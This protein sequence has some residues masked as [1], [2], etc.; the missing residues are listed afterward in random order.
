MKQLTLQEQYNLI[1]EGKGD[2]SHFHKQVLKQFPNL[3]TAQSSYNQVVTVLK[4][5]QIISENTTSDTSSEP[6]WFNIFKNNIN[7]LNEEIKAEEKKTSK[8]VEDIQSHNYDY[9]DKKSIDNHSGA[10]F[11]LGFYVE[12][13][14]P[15]NADKT[16][17]EIRNIVVKNLAKDSLYYV[18]DGQF[19]VKGLGYKDEAPGLGKTKEVKGKYASSGME[20]VKLSEAIKKLA[21]KILTEG[22]KKDVTFDYTFEELQYDGDY[23]NIQATIE[24]EVELGE[25]EDVNW[26]IENITLATKFSDNLDEYVLVELT[27]GQV[28]EINRIVKNTFYNDVADV[29]IERAS[30]EEDMY[31]KGG[32][33]EAKKKPSAGLTKK[34]KSTISKK[35]KAGKDIGKKGKGFEKIEKAAEKKY[36]SKEA[37]KKVAA[38]AMWKNLAKKKVNE[39]LDILNKQTEYINPDYTHFAIRKSDELIVAGWDYMGVDKEDII[40][41]S[42]I[43]LKD[44]FPNNSFSDFRLMTKESLMNKG[45]DPYDSE[46]WDTSIKENDDLMARI[47]ASMKRQVDPKNPEKG[48]PFSDPKKL[49]PNVKI[50]KDKDNE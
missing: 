7:S 43:D 9:K 11:L 44:M 38:A 46:N 39:A 40:Y 5:K 3:F 16:V 21:K 30:G 23:Y 47:K 49:P 26:N 48:K 17:E 1:C 6:N 35:I 28:E 14:D 12:S 41:F 45:I 4:Q 20:P 34:E 10:E 36:G 32:L 22:L 31:D 29:A 13:R 50:D 19:G 24:A 15:K 37:G 42:K 33:A 8:E 27:P 18:K 25:D 2:K